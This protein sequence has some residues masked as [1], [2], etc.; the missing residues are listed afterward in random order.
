MSFY[1]LRN[2]MS[3][4]V[5]D[6][7]I[8]GLSAH[9][10]PISFENSAR[11]SAGSSVEELG[12][13][14]PYRLNRLIGRGGMGLVYEAVDLRLNRRVAVKVLLNPTHTDGRSERF[15][16]EA[17]STARL[18]HP[19][20]VQ[21]HDVGHAAGRDY[22]VMPFVDGITLAEALRSRVF[23]YIDI[24][25]ILKTVAEAVH[26]AHK[27][28][29]IHR[30]LKPANIML[31]G[32]SSGSSLLQPKEQPSAIQST[33]TPVVMDFGLAKDLSSEREL[34]VSGIAMGTPAYMPPEQVRGQAAA[35]V[36]CSD[37][38][39]LGATLY[40]M[41][42]GRPP[43]SGNSPIQIMDSILKDDPI[44]PRLVS[45]GI[46]RDLETICLKC[47]EKAPEKRYA[48]A[49]ALACDLQAFIRGD[50]IS[51]RP[52][53]WMYRAWRSC[54]RRPALSVGIGL[55]TAGLMTA[56]LLVW[57]NEKTKMQALLTRENERKVARER[58]LKS[59]QMH[60][61]NA[62][63][64]IEISGG[65]D[66]ADEQRLREGIGFCDDALRENPTLTEA[67]ELAAALHRKLFDKYVEQS[68]W[69]RAEFE[70]YAIL[71]QLPP[72][73][74][75]KKFRLQFEEM[76]DREMDRVKTRI[77]EI[78][79]DA[80]A[81]TPR[82]PRDKAILE[83]TAMRSDLAVREI[84]QHIYSPFPNCQVVALDAL[85][86]QDSSDLVLHFV[87]LMQPLTRGG[88]RIPVEVQVAAMRAI[89]RQDK[90][91]K[92]A[93]YK[94]VIQRIKAEE[95]QFR[96]EMFRL[97]AEDYIA[98]VKRRSIELK[99]EAVLPPPQ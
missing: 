34:S 84:A 64:L 56:L 30:D 15:L 51:A 87:A 45:S 71:R 16:R 9:V 72:T 22:I 57:Q 33:Y 53:T 24:A 39:A 36:P 17:T 83:L 54:L 42:T 60:L 23:S 37:V 43:F 29:V 96:S 86:W 80:K 19:N 90:G 92:P 81:R 13:L 44:R 50:A 69:A 6:G 47:L 38:Y 67:R 35:I 27:N 55:G 1:E 95:R 70:L 76:R 68:D 32:S 93:A 77:G 79:D 61:S 74:E 65:I 78:F 21:I 82:I 98:Y 8:S 10:Q 20:I 41:L 4:R 5:N 62:R 99:E 63:V 46:P 7:S 25:A 2:A 52:R 58:T 12:E 66:K 97:I 31:A 48:S 91:E 49:D 85:A 40:E 88:N 26:F 73:E 18:Q 3:L 89:F 14:G 75:T 28:G 94:A 59:A 11:G